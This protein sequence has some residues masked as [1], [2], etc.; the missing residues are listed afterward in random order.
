MISE[1][2]LRDQAVEEAVL[3]ICEREATIERMEEEKSLVQAFD[4]EYSQ[5]P[6]SSPPQLDWSREQDEQSERPSRNIKALNRAPSF[7]SDQSKS[8]EALRSLYRSNQVE[9]P[10][11]PEL[12]EEVD[13]AVSEDSDD[14]HSPQLSVL[15]E[16]SFTSVYGRERSV[17]GM[18]QAEQ[19]THYPIDS[20]AKSSP[21]AILPRLDRAKFLSLDHVASSPI[22]RIEGLKS[23]LESTL[24]NSK[25]LSISSSTIDMSRKSSGSSAKVQ[26]YTNEYLHNHMPP[27]PD[28]MSTNA[29]RH[30]RN[31]FDTFEKS[32]GS[33]DDRNSSDS[34]HVTEKRALPH[35]HSAKSSSTVQQNHHGHPSS[36]PH[37]SEDVTLG[38]GSHAGRTSIGADISSSTD[39]WLATAQEYGDQKLR[40]GVEPPR[41]FDFSSTDDLPEDST[42]SI[43]RN[44]M[45]N[46]DHV[47]GRT[48]GRI[49]R[50]RSMRMGSEPIMSPKIDRGDDAA[51]EKANKAEA[52]EGQIS[53]RFQSKP[54]VTSKF[55]S[56]PPLSYSGTNT[57]INNPASSSPE[58]S[59]NIGRKGSLSKRSRLPGFL[60][61]RSETVP[62]L[63]AFLASESSDAK[64]PQASQQDKPS[65]KKR[66]NSICG[67]P[68]I[69]RLADLRKNSQTSPGNKSSGLSAV[70][71]DIKDNRTQRGT[72]GSRTI[73]TGRNVDGRPSTSGSLDSRLPLPVSSPPGYGSKQK[74]SRGRGFG[75]DGADDSDGELCEYETYIPDRKSMS[76]LQDHG[77]PRTDISGKSDGNSESKM[78][79]LKG[80]VMKSFGRRG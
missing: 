47:S 60:G 73:K 77:S 22:R 19:N 24:R 4:M 63:S 13:E 41:M 6:R 48:S 39:T 15:S 56:K 52:K 20:H 10:D 9:N 1:L 18:G 49:P 67:N 54:P 3:I 62:N 76:R 53:N 28:T 64:P 14:S 44:L 50:S 74:A 8:T 5:N 46:N 31:S 16:S 29:L 59:A 71:P 55:L 11:L 68:T 79:K 40:L 7:L 12:T 75:G 30:Q 43:V 26:P 38:Q 36:R 45:F 27:T 57:T 34:R 51:Y 80:V 33:D 2:E 17:I 25:G 66:N 32:S 42:K 69:A 61:G 70:P 72:I 65:P 37:S 21:A 58:T 35:L 78:G 23:R